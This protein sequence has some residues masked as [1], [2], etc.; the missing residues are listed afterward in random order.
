M[1][2]KDYIYIRASGSGLHLTFFLKGLKSNYEWELITKYFIWKSKLPNTKNATELVYGIDKETVLSS[3]RKTSE[4]G[5]WNKLKMDLKKD[6]DYLNYA[7]YLSVDDFLKAKEYPF[8]DDFEKVKYPERYRFIDVP[9]KLL[10]DTRDCKPLENEALPTKKAGS[11]IETA[12]KRNIIEF[13]GVISPDDIASEVRLTPY[14]DIL[15][16]SETQWYARQFLVKYLRW[17]L[18]LSKNDIL[19]LIDVYNA[20]SDYNPRITAY[21]VAK[22][23]REG[24]AETKDKKPVRKETLAK[25]GLL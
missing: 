9:D 12:G 8:C 11:K 17:G 1:S 14:W 7:T 3:D 21:Y 5:S 24:T 6:V 23:F 13:A 4:F 19:E 25:Y 10:R 2:S 18:N 20:W 15:R 22:H 16:D